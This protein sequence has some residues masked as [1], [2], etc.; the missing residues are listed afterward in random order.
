M[1]DYGAYSFC[2]FSS[3]N[4]SRLQ[5]GFFIFSV[6]S[7]RLLIYF[8]ITYHLSVLLYLE[9]PVCSSLSISSHV[10]K[11]KLNELAYETK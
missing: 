9:F 2:R 1:A 6:R 4:I 11:L 8:H 5:I 3:L 10:I 7:Y